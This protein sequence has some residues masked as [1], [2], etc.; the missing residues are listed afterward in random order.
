HVPGTYSSIMRKRTC[1]VT[2]PG[3]LVALV[4]LCGVFTVA[5]TAS[6]PGDLTDDARAFV[7]IPAVAGYE[8]QL[9]TAIAGRLKPFSPQVDNQGNVVFSVG[10]GAPHRLIVTAIDEPGFVAS[11]ITSDGYV[12][13]QRLP[14]MGNLP[15]FNELYSAQPVKIGT[16]QHSWINGSVAGIS[17]HLEPQR[18]HSPSPADLDNI[19]VDIGASSAGEARSAGVDLLNPIA[20]DRKFYQMG[21]GEWTAPAI[22]DRFGTAALIEV[23]R[24][25]DRA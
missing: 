15:L 13:V 2:I 18:Q 7:E 4:L 22:G 20:I 5:Q 9:A 14:Q 19:Y 23:I 24:N 6:I 3:F 12:T 10:T 16:R 8:Q 1:V 21:N 17:I 25:L 11:G